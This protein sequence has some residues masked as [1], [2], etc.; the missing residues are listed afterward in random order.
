MAISGWSV[1]GGGLQRTRLLN[2]IFSAATCFS[3]ATGF[4]RTRTMLDQ[5]DYNWLGGTL[6]SDQPAWL[7]EHNVIAAGKMLWPAHTLPDFKLTADC[8]A[9][10]KGI[11]LSKPFT[12]D[13]KTHDP[14][15]GI[16]PGYFQ[17]TAP[18]CGAV[19]FGETG[20]GI[21]ATIRRKHSTTFSARIRMSPS[22]S[23]AECR[24]MG[25]SA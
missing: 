7:G 1:K 14:L 13:G 20:K 12:L 2:N 8:D 21:E 16:M 19:Q 15:P 25:A 6:Y 18:D 5:C 24:T 9:R 11:D 17:G 4:R 3:A 22:V 10:A 23:V